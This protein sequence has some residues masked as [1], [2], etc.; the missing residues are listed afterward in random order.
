[1]NDYSLAVGIRE[2][3]AISAER[4]PQV[5][6]TDTGIGER[7]ERSAES[8]AHPLPRRDPA[9]FHGLLGELVEA[10]DPHTEASGEGILVSLLAGAGALIGPKPHVMIG[11]TRHP[12]LVWPLLFGRTGSG[13]KGEAGNA[14]KQYLRAAVDPLDPDAFVRISVSGLSSGEGLIERI[15]DPVEQADLE[16]DDRPPRRGITE[17]PGTEDK[18]LLVVESEFAS[19]MARSKRETNTLSGVLR[20]AWEGGALGVLTKAMVRASSSHVAIVGH[21]TP[22]EFRLRM[23]AAE[24]GG[25]TYNRFLPIYVERSKR[26]PLPEPMDPVS[27]STYGAMLREAIARAKNRGDIRM[28]DRAR[29][30]WIEELYGEFTGSEDDEFMW[31]EF[32]ERAPAYARRISALFAVLDGRSTVTEADLA[33]TAALVRYSIASAKYVL[34]G[35]HR[36][37]RVD[38]IKRAIDES[39]NRRL[40][41]T[42]VSALFGRHLK[43][44]ELDGLL[45]QVTADGKYVAI[46]VETA[47]RTARIYRPAGAA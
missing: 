10:I 39:D 46:D 15:K 29:E 23:A 1:M 31:S 25:G 40:T 2:R 24:M 6:V 11:A 5:L 27:L 38:R 41:R 44:A 7:S 14:A 17:W 32:T 43:P 33:A 37:P 12:L 26:L 30:L 4:D 36:D 3:S 47:G 20:E 8:E 34:D 21:I 18:R 19:V 42:E 35:R 45:E 9:M 16:D 28:D 22:R 13:R